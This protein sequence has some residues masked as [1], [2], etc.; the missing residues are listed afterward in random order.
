MISRISLFLI[1]SYLAISCTTQ[2]PA[3]VVITDTNIIDVETGEIA[4]GKT[5]EIR[6]GKIAEI[7]NSDNAIDGENIIDGSGKYVI[8]GLWDMHVHFRGGDSLITENKNLLDLF[9]ANGVTTVRDAGGDITPA[10]L[11]WEKQIE[12]G[13]LLG[14][15]IFTS[16][17]KLD[18][19]DPSWAG[20]IELTSVDQV[21]AAF[22]S[23]ESLKVDYVKLYDS[24]IPAD[25]YLAAVKE[26]EKRGLKVTG[27]MPFTV[28]FNEAVEAG[29]DATEHMYYVLKGSSSQEEKIT[30]AVRQGEYGFWA[31]LTEVIETYDEQTAQKTYE[32]MAGSGTAV[33]PTLHIGKVLAQL[34]E[35]D[36]SGDKYLDYIGEGIKETYQ[37]RLQAAKSQSQEATQRRRNLRKLF[38]DMIPDIHN[39]GVNILAG[40][41]SGPYNSFVYPGISLHKELQELETAGLTPLEA[42]Q[43]SVING[44]EFFGVSDEYGKVRPNYVADLLLLNGN[45]LDDIENTE[46][47]H[48]VIVE[49]EPIINDDESTSLLEKV[50]KR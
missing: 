16:G 35:E 11:E 6:D 45:P 49:G 37:G 46:D 38:V 3:E 39:A 4:E 43:T 14:P 17:P 41:D 12:N 50:V 10:I 7:H 19:S 5:I 32:Q 20:S 25:V 22:D 1:I 28:D 48:T 26:A 8:P 13:E 44:P 29:L 36:H 9:I 34:N 21:S 42:L 24:T 2:N 31:A 33:V 15:Q 18:G 27:H 23:L 30:E 47:I 40:S